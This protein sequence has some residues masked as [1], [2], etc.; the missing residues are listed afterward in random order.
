[1][2]ML[3][4]AVLVNFPRHVV[5]QFVFTLKRLHHVQPLRTIHQ[6]RHVLG[7][8]KIQLARGVDGWSGVFGF[9]V[10]FLCLTQVVLDMGVVHCGRVSPAT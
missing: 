4:P 10:L 7:Q 1:M 8:V 3:F 6:I 2:R 9:A 5:E